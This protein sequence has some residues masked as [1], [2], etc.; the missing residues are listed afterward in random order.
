MYTAIVTGGLG[1]IGSNLINFL[2]E[3]KFKII[4][5]DKVSYSSNFKNIKENINNYKFYKLDINNKKKFYKIV[6]LY[7]PNVIFNLAAET[8]VDRS[9]DKPI[10]FI[11]SNYIGLFFVLE[12]LKKLKNKCL[13]IQVSTDEVYGDVKKKSNESDKLNPSS[14]YSATK[15]ASDLLIKSY[16]RSFG[17]KAII[18]RCCNNFG[19]NQFPEKFIPNSIYKILNNDKIPIYSKGKNIREWIYVKD[20]CRALYQIFKKGKSGEIYNIGTGNL[21]N[22]YNLAKKIIKIFEKIRD[23]KF[24]KKLI[25]FV[26]DRPGHDFKYSLNLSKIKK[27]I[28]IKRNNFEIDLKKTIEWYLV[29]YKNNYFPKKLLGVRQG[30]LKW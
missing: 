17:V 13:L 28:R 27:I 1:F 7:K 6:K 24:K 21:I 22:N 9:I 25:S 11:K 3:K 19:P 8:H 16:I 10:E 20:H 18:T 5:I 23:K 26:K 12:T 2:S 15:A 30:L 14:P 29:N 4:N